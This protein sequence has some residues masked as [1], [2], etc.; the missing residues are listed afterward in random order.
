MDE[1]WLS[2]SIK[3]VKARL[4]QERV[5]IERE[6]MMFVHGNTVSALPIHQR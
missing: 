5:G 6:Q 3:E 1:L 4:A 2:D